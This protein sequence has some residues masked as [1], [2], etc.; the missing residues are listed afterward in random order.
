MEDLMKRMMEAMMGNM[1]ELIFEAENQMMSGF[2]PP[3]SKPQNPRDEM[4]RFPDSDMKFG[5]EPAI[6]PNSKQDIIVDAKEDEPE[7]WGRMNPNFFSHSTPSEE[8]KE[9]GRS[10]SRH[11]SRSTMRSSSLSADGTR[12]DKVVEEVNGKT[13]ATTTFTYP[14]GTTRTE[15]IENP[16]VLSREETELPKSWSKWAEFWK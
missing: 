9:R 6:I 14:D 8:Q 15:I 13:Q 11:Y 16:A 4:L 10:I 1:T 5:N 2:T 12:I 7:K 3:S